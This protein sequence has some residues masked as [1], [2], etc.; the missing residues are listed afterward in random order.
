MTEEEK[1]LREN[2]LEYIWEF[3]FKDEID[4]AKLIQTQAVFSDAIT[5]GFHV[6]LDP[7]STR[8]KSSE[9]A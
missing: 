9:I 1:V 2:I 4:I 8:I 5:A 6:R 3:Y 7:S